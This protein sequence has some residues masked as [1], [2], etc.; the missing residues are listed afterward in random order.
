[1]KLLSNFKK[2][3]FILAEFDRLIKKSQ[4]KEGRFQDFVNIE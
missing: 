2:G 3:K 4:K 1:M